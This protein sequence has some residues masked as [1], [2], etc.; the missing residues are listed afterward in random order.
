[1]SSEFL[2]DEIQICRRILEE[3]MGCVVEIRQFEKVGKIGRF[4]VND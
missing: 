4:V 1:M 3:I 2:R